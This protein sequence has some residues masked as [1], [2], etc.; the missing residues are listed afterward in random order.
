VAHAEDADLV[1]RD[2]QALR[3]LGRGEALLVF[4]FGPLGARTDLGRAL[5]RCGRE[6]VDRPHAAQVGVAPRGARDVPAG[7]RGRI[8]LGRRNRV[9]GER[10]RRERQGKQQGRSQ[11]GGYAR[12]LHDTLPV[13]AASMPEIARVSMPRGRRRL[14]RL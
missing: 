14:A 8:V 7:G 12:D 1:L 2:D 9:L 10:R 11:R 13:F 5:A 4:L 3:L 6:V